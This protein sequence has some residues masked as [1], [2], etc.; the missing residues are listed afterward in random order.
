MHREP[1]LA[2]GCD[3]L[4]LFSPVDTKNIF[5]RPT[6]NIEHI[7][8]TSSNFLADDS[9]SS[10]IICTRGCDSASGI[11]IARS[12]SPELR[13]DVSSSSPVFFSFSSASCFNRAVY[14]WKDFRSVGLEEV[15]LASSSGKLSQ[16]G[17]TSGKICPALCE[18]LAD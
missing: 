16:A 13:A 3:F 5:L 6:L 4:D 17:S 1:F 8:T 18:A 11:W 12:A 14:C 2:G 9:A 10:L 7:L 15:R